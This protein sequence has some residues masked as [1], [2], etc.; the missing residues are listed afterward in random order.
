MGG[1]EGSWRKEGMREKGEKEEGSLTKSNR[2]GKGLG[3]GEDD[4]KDE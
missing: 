3:L 4:G 1:C 2:R